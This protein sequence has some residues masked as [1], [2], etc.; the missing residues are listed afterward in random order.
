MIKTILKDNSTCC[1]MC[2][3]MLKVGTE[4]FIDNDNDVICKNCRKEF[5]PSKFT[6]IES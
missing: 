4:I 2:F 5:E 3:E 1:S 6:I